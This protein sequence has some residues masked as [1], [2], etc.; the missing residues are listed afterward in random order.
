MYPNPQYDYDYGP[1]GPLAPLQAR[2]ISPD[3]PV[4]I[5][6]PIGWVPLVLKL[7]EDLAAIL[8]DYT[9][10]Q[11][12]EKFAELRFY[13]DSYGVGRDDPRYALARDLISEAEAQSMRTCQICGQP[14]V[15]QDDLRWHA[16]LCDEHAS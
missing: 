14:G 16:T 9:I 8:P 1:D 11:V 10:G 5:S 3:F 15:F 2:S 4:M 6:P 13:I 7:N 12:K